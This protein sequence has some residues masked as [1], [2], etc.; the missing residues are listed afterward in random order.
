MLAGAFLPGQVVLEKKG[1]IEMLSMIAGLSV[2]LA[3]GAAVPAGLKGEAKTEVVY[4][5]GI[6]GFG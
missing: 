2:A 3:I 1:S 4:T 6:S 5:F